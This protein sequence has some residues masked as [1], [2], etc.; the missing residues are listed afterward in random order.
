MEIS[1]SLVIETLRS[2]MDVL[3]RD[4]HVRNI[5]IFGSVARGEQ[6]A[7]SDIDVL[8]E[9]STPISFFKFIRLE[10]FLSDLLHR[11]V[12]L[13]TKNA[14]KPQIREEIL[15]DLVSV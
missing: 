5:G 7:P 1:S 10:N 3:R 14:L 2:R 13:V 12:D 6:V 15:D 8:V 4:F 11:K 9:F